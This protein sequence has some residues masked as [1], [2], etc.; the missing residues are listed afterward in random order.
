MPEKTLIA[1]RWS[2]FAKHCRMN[3]KYSRPTLAEKVIVIGCPSSGGR[4][5]GHS[6][7]FD[8]TEICNSELRRVWQDQ[9]YAL[10]LLQTQPQQP[11]PGTIYVRSQIPVRAN[12]MAASK[13]HFLSATFPDVTVQK[14]I[15]E[16]KESRILTCLAHSAIF[17]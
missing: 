16:I 7:D 15:G 3:Y 4:R 1:Q 2:N 9:Q 13:G 17:C 12:R 14:L 8:Y 11:I 6:T 5:N 10:L